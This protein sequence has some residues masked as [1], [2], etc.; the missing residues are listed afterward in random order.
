M[1]VDVLVVELVLVLVDDVEDVLVLVV[2]LVLVLLLVV[3]VVVHTPQ[4]AGHRCRTR[5]PNTSLLH[6]VTG[7][8]LQSSLS[9]CKCC[10]NVKFCSN[11]QV[12][13]CGHDSIRGGGVE[14][15]SK[16]LV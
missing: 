11:L 4:C 13:W 2:E 8:S 16:V 3:V 14:D 10:L 12:S 5:S 1:P 6:I 15:Q 7:I 9:G